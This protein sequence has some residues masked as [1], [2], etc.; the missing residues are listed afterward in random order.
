MEFSSQKLRFCGKMSFVVNLNSSGGRREMT[1]RKRQRRGGANEKG[2][3][4][5][6]QNSSRQKYQD[7]DN[8]KHEFVFSDRGLTC[9]INL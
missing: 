3:I 4:E 8:H 5:K 6:P 1:P 2:K 7:F 9:G